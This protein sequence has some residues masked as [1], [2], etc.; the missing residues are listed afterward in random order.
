MQGRDVATN[1][2]RKSQVNQRE[3]INGLNN[4]IKTIFDIAG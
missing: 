2:K 4:A 1:N 3:Q